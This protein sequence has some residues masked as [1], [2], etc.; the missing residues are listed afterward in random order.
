MVRTLDGR[1]PADIWQQHDGLRTPDDRPLAGVVL[2]LRD[3]Q[4]GLPVSSGQALPGTYESGVI[5]ALTDAAAT[6]SFPACRLART[7]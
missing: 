5:T 2:E 3:A 6:T 4:T 1:P 7:T